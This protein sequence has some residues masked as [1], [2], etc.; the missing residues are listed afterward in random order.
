[1][2]S[3]NKIK[4]LRGT[5]SPLGATINKNGVNFSIASKTA[6]EVY[7]CLFSEEKETHK[8]KLHKTG[9]I[10]HIFI[11][12]IKAGQLYAYRADGEYSPENGL[13]FNKNKLLID[14]YAKALQ[15]EVVCS[16]ENNDNNDKDNKNNIPKSLVVDTSFD[17][18][19]VSKPQTHLKDTIIY[20]TH[21]KGM[22]MLHPDVPKEHKG[23]FLGMCHD[24]IIRHL[25]ELG[26]TAIEIMPIQTFIT[27]GFLIDKG[28]SNYWGYSPLNY[29]SIYNDYGTLDEF[30]QMI[31]KYHEDGLE[32]IMDVVYNHTCEG[33]H[34]GPTYSFKGIDNPSYY[35]LNKDAIACSYHNHTGCGNSFNIDSEIGLKI[36]LDSMLYFSEE[37]QVD[38]FRFDLATTLLRDLGTLDKSRL[39]TEIASNKKLANLKLIA[40][41]W[42]IGPNG[43]QL[44]RFKS[45]FCEWN[46]SFR[47]STRAFWK[48]DECEIKNFARN[49]SGSENIFKN[50]EY[51]A[52][53]S[54]NF[55]TAHDGFTLEDLVSYND[56][57]N[58][59]NLEE[60]RDGN[61]YNLSCNYG[62][63]GKT[64]DKEIK[65]IRLRQ[66]KNLITTNI[67]SKGVPMILAG[68]EI[69]NSQL[70]NNN[71]YCQ[72]NPIGW[73]NWDKVK[74]EDLEFK[75][76]V[77]NIIKFRKINGKLI[78]NKFLTNSN[79]KWY[80]ST[81]ELM[82]NECWDTPYIKHLN[83]TLDSKFI[84]LFNS[85]EKDIEFKLP[86]VASG[87]II[88][89]TYEKDSFKKK[90]LNEATSVLVR[91]RSIVVIKVK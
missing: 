21:I 38:G 50:H 33:N 47:N 27:E 56:K 61:N 68:D 30:K 34:E 91:N 26:I 10:F 54:I 48:G 83:L 19:E 14:P 51:G 57:H 80:S 5:T 11:E 2:V 70:G 55:I 1:M 65:K 85:H 69:G 9:H 63:E 60:N 43:Y 7:L 6:Q 12:G 53:S 28:L 88:L 35:I 89:N 87:K 42:D 13:R 15:G 45:K 58:E 49:I 84:F 39:L 8:I 66:K 59:A 77:E 67:L 31:K 72:D 29:F 75:A 64:S 82:T 4:T 73:I 81:G 78:N 90:I 24:S 71:T 44:G 18:G 3:V 16:I 23:R 25:K 36:V 52:L 41:P 86:K 17:W 32:V 79:A 20:E 74:K 76:F 62:V 37:C 40:E 46:D 22:T